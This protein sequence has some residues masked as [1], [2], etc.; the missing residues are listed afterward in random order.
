MRIQTYQEPVVAE[1][2]LHSSQQSIYPLY[3][4]DLRYHFFDGGKMVLC[5]SWKYAF[6]LKIEH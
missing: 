2:A 3:L 4:L 5:C 6:P 1:E